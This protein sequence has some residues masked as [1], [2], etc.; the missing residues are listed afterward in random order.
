MSQTKMSSPDVHHSSASY[1]VS[2]QYSFAHSLPVRA[3]ATLP[4]YAKT[5]VALVGGL[6]PHSDENL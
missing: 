1:N 2:T 5:M 3:R 6:S 4:I